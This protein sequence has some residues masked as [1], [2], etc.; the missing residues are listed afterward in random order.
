MNDNKE[1]KTNKDE[2]NRISIK[3]FREEGYLQ[4][5]NRRFL[6]IL[7]L[8]LE[9]II[10]DEDI[11]IENIKEK[12]KKAEI[13]DKK[14]KDILYTLLNKVEDHYC[15]GGIWDYRDD[16]EGMI[17]GEY[18]YKD[19]KNKDM[20]KKAEK[21]KEE[22]FE[23]LDNRMDRFGFGVQPTDKKLFDIEKIK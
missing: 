1:S 5:L 18:M 20:E 10:I 7:G 6:H 22:C 17:F 3:K 12:V 11:D 19:E 8:A 9:V 15:L 4:E 14:E 21:V 2:V 23:K 13:F 16:P